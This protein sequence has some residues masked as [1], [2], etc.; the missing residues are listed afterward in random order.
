MSILWMNFTTVLSPL[1]DREPDPLID[2]VPEYSKLAS[3]R[4]TP[5]ESIEEGSKE[6]PIIERKLSKHDA[7][8][9]RS[10]KSYLSLSGPPLLDGFNNVL[11]GL[12]ISGQANLV[13]RPFYLSLILRIFIVGLAFVRTTQTMM[14]VND[15]GLLN[16]RD[17][18]NPIFI[19]IGIL[20][21]IT[22]CSL[23][24]V[25]VY[26]V[27]FNM[28]IFY[29]VIRKPNLCFLR[30]DIMRTIGEKSGSMVVVVIIIH[31]IATNMVRAIDLE[32]YVE[33]FDVTSL[34]LDIYANSVA[35]LSWVGVSFLDFYIRVC[36]GHWLLGLRDHL[37]FQFSY[38]RQTPNIMNKPDGGTE[39]ELPYRGKLKLISMDDI[40]R[41]LN[42][43]DD[44]LELM[45]SSH[46]LSLV[47]ITLN[48]F[49]ANGAWIILGFHLLS[50]Q[51][52]Y[53]HG[54][55]ILFFSFST[56]LGASISYWGDSWL[57]HGLEKLVECI[58]DEYF[59]QSNLSSTITEPCNRS[60]SDSN[61]A[62]DTDDTSIIKSGIKKK[63]VLFFREFEHQF[64][65]HL[66]TPWSNLNLKTHLH[67]IR[68]FASLLAAQIIFK[69]VH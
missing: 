68:A 49:L 9:H 1:L 8:S 34:L 54:P 51:K 47:L 60:H 57:H 5:E 35:I 58:E 45:R 12:M 39:Q 63:H 64:S 19:L 61:E 48:S 23:I 32:D 16:E 28:G 27:T 40:Q 15:L 59:Q 20:A 37:T 43:M 67:I 18:H 22:S 6:K 24:I 65:S 29:K 11:V 33:N 25:N 66:A 31:G 53:Y 2:E 42:N 30:R 3:S 69:H 46:T 44:H 55:I 62:Q 4:K 50:D 52:D 41:N 38:L 14:K 7:Y 36:F 26:I 17:V 56:G 13:D 21:F 10:R